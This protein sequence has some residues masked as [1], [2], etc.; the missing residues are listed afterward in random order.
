MAGSHSRRKGRRGE[1]EVVHAAE[2]HHIP[3]R[4]RQAPGLADNPEDPDLLM[5]GIL[6]VESK[7][8]ATDAGFTCITK[9]LEGHDMLRVRCDGKKAIWVMDDDWFW[10]L[11]TCW[12]DYG[13]P[14]DFVPDQGGTL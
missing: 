5:A 2:A 11:L 10:A 14:T 6:K 9:W 4:R 13:M 8:R 3:C 12:H 1:L 7:L